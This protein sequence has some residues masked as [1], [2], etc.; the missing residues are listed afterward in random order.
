M[1]D[2]FVQGILMN[3]GQNVKTSPRETFLNLIPFVR[4]E[5]L[6]GIETRI[7]VNENSRVRAGG[8]IL[9]MPFGL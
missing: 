3:E 1:M 9:G 5:I 4:R 7:E 2:N 6:D 8:I